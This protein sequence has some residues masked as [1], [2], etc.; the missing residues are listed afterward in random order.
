MSTSPGS[1][2]TRRTSTRSSPARSVMRWLLIVSGR[3]RQREAESC[4]VLV[5]SVQ[6]D[7]AA[8]V[9]D[10]LAA[11]SKSDAGARV[12]SPVVQPLEDHEDT[13]RVLGLDADSVVGDRE[14]PEAVVLPVHRDPDDRRAVPTELDRVADQVLEERRQQRELRAH[15]WQLG[16]LDD[17]VSL[18]YLTRE[19]DPC[20]R[21]GAT[22]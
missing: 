8:I 17:R 3:D 18:A 2:S 12:G 9:L 4:P 11:H 1:S 22:G 15:R 16:H 5:S 19:V 7:L 21:Q 14:Q 6:P 13:I 20:L 10:D